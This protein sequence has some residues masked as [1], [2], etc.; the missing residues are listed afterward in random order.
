[1]PVTGTCK[2]C[3][4]TATLRGSHVLPEFLYKAAYDAIHRA[5]EMKAETGRPCFLQKGYRE[6]MLCGDCEERINRYETYYAHELIVGKRM[7]EI[8]RDTV[9][10]I[11]GLDYA[12]FKLFHLSIVWRAGVSQRDEFRNVKLGPHEDR[13]RQML[14]ND[15]PG[16]PGV[17]PF[18]GR[19]LFDPSDL[20]ITD[21]VI[22]E[23]EVSR[24]D[25]HFIYIF[26]F[27]G[28]AWFYFISS[29]NVGDLVPVNFAPGKDLILV[30][31][32]LFSYPPIGDFVKQ[33]RDVRRSR[34]LE[35]SGGGERAP[36]ASLG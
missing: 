5:I 27:G 25:A 18:L 12:R 13:L 1:M 23:P 8:L 30:A 7:P 24:V 11:A 20:R 16:D 21:N 14:L 36:N 26:T 19:I 31:Q 33:Y 15:N 32:D 22:V 4:K 10:K 35:Q 29:H 9:V 17:Y 34:L 6:P 2:L 3:K 28:C